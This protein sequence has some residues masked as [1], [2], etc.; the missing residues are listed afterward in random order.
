MASQ[1]RAGNGHDFCKAGVGVL[2]AFELFHVARRSSRKS[3]EGRRPI[4]RAAQAVFLGL[5]IAAIV[6]PK[7]RV[8]PASQIRSRAGPCLQPHFI[9]DW[10]ALV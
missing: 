5:H 1:A 3:L 7:D 2:F 8:V 6:A 9:F 10:D 4:F